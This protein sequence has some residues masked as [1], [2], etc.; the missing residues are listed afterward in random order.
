MKATIINKDQSTQFQKQALTKFY[1]K[2]VFDK[3]LVRRNQNKKF[4]NNSSLYYGLG[5]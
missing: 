2:W 4:S 1:W 3:N 5:K